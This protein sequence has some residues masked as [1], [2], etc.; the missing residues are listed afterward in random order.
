MALPL[1][2][3]DPRFSALLASAPGGVWVADADGR[4]L[5]ANAAACRMLGR[6]DGDL[7]TVGTDAL[8][9]IDRAEG[10][11]RRARASQGTALWTPE[12]F[13]RPDGSLFWAETV[14]T[15]LEAEGVFVTHL[16]SLEESPE[17]H[18]NW[19][20]LAASD[21]PLV[22]VDHAAGTL[23]EVNEAYARAR[24]FRPEEMVGMSLDR[25][26]APHEAGRLDQVRALLEQ[27]G[28]LV[29]ETVNLRRDG[30]AFPVLV[31]TTLIRDPDGTPRYRISYVLDL[32]GLKRAEAEREKSS[33][34]LRTLLDTLPDL[35]WLKDLR[36]VYLECNA[37]FEKLFGAPREEIVGRTDYDFVPPALADFF[38]AHDLRAVEFGGPS[39]NEEEITFKSDGHTEI[40]EALKTPVLG[41]GGRVMGVLGIA[42]DI[43]L[44]KLT[45]E[46]LRVSEEKF[47][48]AFYTAPL[49]ATLSRKEDGRIIEVNDK[50]CE[51]LG[52]AR[53]EILGHTSLE[54]G[55]FRPE[56]RQRLLEALRPSG[57]VHG[58]ELPAGTKDGRDIPCL[59]FAEE[60]R[61]AREDLLLVMALDIRERKVAEDLQRRLDEERHQMQKLESLGSLAS[62]VAHDMN[63]VLA[64]IQAVTETLQGG[65][66]MDPELARPLRIIQL[67]A[68]RGRD[69]VRGL[70]NFSRKDLREP[71]VLDLNGLV[72][73]E[74]ELLSRTTFQK[75]RL[76]VDLAEPPPIVV[77]ERGS[78]AAA[79]MNLCVNAV[80]AMPGGGTLT[81]R[82]RLLAGS[83]VELQ[84]EDTGE[85]MPPEVLHRALEP[86]YTTKPIG[87]G[88]GMGLAMAYATL[89]AHGGSL[90][91]Q[92]APGRGTLVTLRLPAGAPAEEAAA[93]QPGLR[94]PLP[95]RRILLVDDDPLILESV[96]AL[97]E[98]LGQE[99][100]A[101]PSGME[102]LARIET[103][104]AFDLV[105]LDLN[106]P[107][108]NGAE[109]LTALRRMRPG[110]PVLLSTGFLDEETRDQVEAD[111]RAWALLKPYSKVTLE[112]KLLEIDAALR[113]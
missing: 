108:L 30:S 24:G 29:L 31:D 104:E 27:E 113:A 5:D 68:S 28:H 10:D 42:R 23:V 111:P 90:D 25:I 17:A 98:A 86:F 101:V 89:K 88:T 56:V 9:G 82:T 67:A 12:G 78:L 107:G 51:V 13:R 80:D 79:L 37:R 58:L 96:A 18:L 92:S 95:A 50:Y 106:M 97:I 6:G 20:A 100:A 99:V 15:W 49:L 93:S 73:E 65:G 75:V 112:R 26:V 52:F 55:V 81:L 2:P 7:R 33:A 70:V 57:N 62:G 91:L 60:F 21:L 76:V 4:I 109:T 14:T 47:H 11:A 36:G 103:G 110:L 40:V 84:V 72:S 61:V 45:E 46:R 94:T 53:E 34:L 48:E 77:G 74:V 8:A 71:E 85:G 69:L 83:Q 41:P 19:R 32:S 44:R 38:R 39:M 22:L 102:A 16:R 35:V 87:K 43:T 64:A 63:N 105:V 66:A 3:A 54:L 1:P 59:F